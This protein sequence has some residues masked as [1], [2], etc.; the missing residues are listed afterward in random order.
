[1]RVF[2]DTNVLVSAFATRGLCADVLREVMI[3]HEV[4]VSKHVLDELR[5]VL[6]SKLN[7]PK[8]IADD[9]VDLVR[10]ASSMASSGRPLD[11][12]LRDAND[13][14]ILAAAVASDADVFL[15]GDAELLA[16]GHCQRMLMSSPR[17]FWEKLTQREK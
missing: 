3:R 10:E 13:A 4:I 15:T 17:Q 7:L 1:M 8:A 9:A 16:L 14:R 6:R 11:I 5:R 12:E 2:L